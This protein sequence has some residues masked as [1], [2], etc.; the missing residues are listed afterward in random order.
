MEWYETKKRQHVDYKKST[1][2]WTFIVTCLINAKQLNN[3]TC[4]YVA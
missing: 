2:Q 1:S 3:T 4:T